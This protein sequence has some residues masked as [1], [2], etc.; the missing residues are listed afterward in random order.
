MA[1]GVAAAAMGLLAIDGTV[2]GTAVAMRKYRW[3]KRPL[4]VFA[5]S[6]AH[7]ELKRQ[8]GLLAGQTAGLR[9]RDMVVIYVVGSTVSTQLGAGPGMSA[10]ALRSR[11]GISASSFRTILVGKDGGAKISSRAPLAVTRLF[12][13]IDAMPMRRQEIRRSSG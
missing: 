3:E 1:N 4:L 6:A 8:R 7:L 5:P 13:T 10:S 11:Y 9:E 2:C 12:A